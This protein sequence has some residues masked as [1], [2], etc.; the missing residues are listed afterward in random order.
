M[1]IAF[2]Y[3]HSF[4]PDE[5]AAWWG[6]YRTQCSFRAGTLRNTVPVL[7]WRPERCSGP[8]QF[9]AGL[10]WPLNVFGHRADWCRPPKKALPCVIARN[11]RHCAWKSVTDHFSRRV[12]EKLIRI[13]KDKALYF[14]Y[15]PRRSLRVDWHTFWVMCSPR[16]RNQFCKVLS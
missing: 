15:L 5:F 9:K 8:F 10:I 6:L 4:S 16:G 3:G 12:R 14:T 2:A 7:F 13:K 11:L 1:E